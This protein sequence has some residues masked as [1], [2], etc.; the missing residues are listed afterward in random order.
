[1]TKWP[2]H[3]K[4]V[5]SETSDLLQYYPLTLPHSEVSFEFPNP[6]VQEEASHPPLLL[7]R[8]Q[9]G[10]LGFRDEGKGCFPLRSGSG[11]QQEGVLALEEAQQPTVWEWLLNDVIWVRSQES[12][13]LP[14]SGRACL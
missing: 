6:V 2:F 4:L 7:G 5:P 8:P 10:L 9:G 1:M 3:N 12:T 11:V 13:I 14:G